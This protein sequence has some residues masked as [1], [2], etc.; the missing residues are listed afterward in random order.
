MNRPDVTVAITGHS[1]TVLAGPTMRSAEIA[2]RAAEAEGFRVER[3]IGL[4]N[5]TETCREFFNQPAFKAWSI[6]EF[7]LSDQ[8]RARNALVDIAGGRWIA[9]LD[10]DDLFSENWLVLAAKRLADAEARDEKTIV[11]PELN[12]L[13]DRN[14]SI[15]I[16]TSQADPLFNPWYFYFSNYYDTLAMAPRAAHLE[17]P[18]AERD[19]PSGF[20]YEDWQW[21]IETMAAGWKH[22]IATD[23]I[24]F[25]RRRDMS[26][27]IR[28]GQRVCVFR[29]IEPMAIDRIKDLGGGPAG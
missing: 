10:A 28:T 14:G 24:I 3:L 16:K 20:A 21:G 2:I 26:Q 1:E 27:T 4:D 25:K 22:V 7:K 6:T 13:F 5:P 12:W 23:T 9:F 17:S 19:I 29:P 18:Y 15:L 11:H 8:G